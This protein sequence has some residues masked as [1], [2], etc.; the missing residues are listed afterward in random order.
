M[1]ND[2]VEPAP[3]TLILID[4]PKDYTSARV[5]NII[6]KKL[7]IKKAGHSGTLDPKATGLLI[8]CTGKKTK[9]LS[10]MI[11]YDKEYEGEMVLGESTPSFDSETEVNKTRSIDKISGDL[12]LSTA[13]SLNGEI[14]QIPPMY[15]AIKHK[16]K[17][18]YK[19]A[20]KNK[21]VER[22]PRKVFIKEFEIKR[23][24]LPL[25]YFKVSCS[26]GTYVRTLI[27]DFGEML[28][29]GAYLKELR[30]T[31]IG[32]FDVKDSF[33]L[34]D[35]LSGNLTNNRFSEILANTC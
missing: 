13:N 35:F 4:K 6:K 3:G 16:G 32:P 30:R 33:K 25:V 10:E 8:I 15:S 9:L 22:T 18:L 27:N 20:R 34:V 5:V 14:E 29:T 19:Y 2:T 1:K 26:K 28:G 21:E 11:L 23:I 17:P 7:N 12:I 31:R 24:D